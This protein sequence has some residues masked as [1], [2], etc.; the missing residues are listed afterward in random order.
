[1]ARSNSTTI[2]VAELIARLQ[3]LPPEVQEYLVHIALDD[4]ADAKWDSHLRD[5]MVEHKQK[6]VVLDNWP[7]IDF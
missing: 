2:T 3:A 5:V 1:M 7:E 6:E 4:E